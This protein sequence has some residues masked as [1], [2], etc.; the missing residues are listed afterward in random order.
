MEDAPVCYTI[1][2]SSQTAG[3]FIRLLKRYGIEYL[4]DVRSAP[5][6]AY[7]PQFNGEIIRKTLKT[8]GITYT[9]M[10]K[11]LGARHSGHDLQFEDGQVDF[12][13]VRETAGFIHGI[14]KILR[15]AK[16]GQ[17]ALMCSEKDPF[18]CHRFCLI[19]P[20]LEAAGARVVHI[21][22]DGS[23]VSNGELEERL[24][25]KYRPNYNQIDLFEPEKT[26]GE[27]LAECYAEHN[28]LI[29]YRKEEEENRP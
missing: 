28:R 23:T 14:E 10:G 12:S 24:L 26:R 6:S 21:L 25:G 16:Q 27:H 9:Y 17:T 20:A 18:E 4:I 11:E 3:E 13:K 7:A 15:G 2:H 8:D 1:G 19:T 5:Y 29:G 22:Q